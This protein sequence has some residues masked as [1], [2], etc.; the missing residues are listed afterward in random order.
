QGPQTPKK[1]EYHPRRPPLGVRE[2][3]HTGRV[4][5]SK[6]KIVS[7]NQDVLDHSFVALAAPG[8]ITNDLL[9]TLTQSPQA[10]LHAAEPPVRLERRPDLR[11][12]CREAREVHQVEQLM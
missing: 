3:G 10:L 7:I 8:E 12:D 11:V 9:H 5:T 4:R 2:P 1:A 6:R